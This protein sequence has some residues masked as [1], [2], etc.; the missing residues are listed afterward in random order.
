MGVILLGLGRVSTTNKSKFIYEKV[1]RIS[2]KS[3]KK[4]ISK[5]WDLKKNISQ[6]LN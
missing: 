2:K 4:K 1:G 3:Y 5:E 6:W